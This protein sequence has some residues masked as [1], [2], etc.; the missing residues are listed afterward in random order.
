MGA[1][2]RSCGGGAARR[3]SR[4]SC[5][6]CSSGPAATST[7]CSARGADVFHHDH[8]HLD[9]AAMTR[10]ACAMSASPSSSSRPGS[11]P[12]PSSAAPGPRL[13]APEQHPRDIE[14]DDDPFAVS[15][16]RPPARPSRLAGQAYA[17]LA[18]TT[19]PGAGADDGTQPRRPR[20]ASAPGVVPKSEARLSEPRETGAAAP[21]RLSRKTLPSAPS[22]SA[23]AGPGPLAPQPRPIGRHV[24]QP[25]SADGIY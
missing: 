21:A 24:T 20:D 22:R 25:W 7:P 15:A 11:S 9:L 12:A 13:P 23:S 6:R 10:A 1:R 19:R 8:F 3:R 18:P 16:A 2:Y 17:G 4:S 14:T 5:A